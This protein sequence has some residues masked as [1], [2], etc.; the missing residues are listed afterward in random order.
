MPDNLT[1]LIETSTLGAPLYQLVAVF[2]LFVVV[3]K[4]LDRILAY[5][6]LA[7]TKKLLSIVQEIDAIRRDSEEEKEELSSIKREMLN[8]ISAEPLVRNA[9]REVK[10]F[11]SMFP[12]TSIYLVTVSVVFIQLVVS[13]GLS[14][15]SRGEAGLHL[16][17]SM[18]AIL[19]I[20]MIIDI[21]LQ[22]LMSWLGRKVRMFLDRHFEE[23]RSRKVLERLAMHRDALDAIVTGLKLQVSSA[24]EQMLTNRCTLKKLSEVQAKLKDNGE[25]DNSLRLELIGIKARA[26]SQID[27]FMTTI[28]GYENQ[29]S[30]CEKMIQDDRDVPEYSSLL[31]EE[32]H[33]LELC[34]EVKRLCEL[35][36]AQVEQMV[37][38][39]DSLFDNE[40]AACCI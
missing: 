22:R 37:A 35:D 24:N 31:D 14:L 12:I 4:L 16:W 2:I 8:K 29:I 19:I 30:L 17:L 28:S 36:K 27:Q 9:F 10:D 33:A 3:P 11:V 21:V 7:Q 32:Y 40:R 15:F 5:S 23:K 6:R 20:L 34:R 25:I 39:L 1:T 18:T 26:K 13:E 38:Y